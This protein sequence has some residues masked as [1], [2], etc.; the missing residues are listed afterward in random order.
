MASSDDEDRNDTGQEEDIT[1]DDDDI[2]VQTAT[3]HTKID[4]IGEE[5]TEYTIRYEI[6]YKKGQ[7]NKTD[8]KKHVS[9]LIIMEKAFDQTELRIIDNKNQRVKSFE[10]AKWM[11]NA[12]YNSHFTV[13]QDEGQRKTVIVHRIRSK[14][15][16]SGL[17]GES[18]VITYLKSSNTFLRAHFWKEDEV[19][20]RDIGFL[21]RYV[22]THHNKE[23]VLRD[24]KER[25][26]FADND[27][28]N[29]QPTPPPFQLI[30]SQ[31]RIK[32]NNKVLKTH[33]YSVQVQEKD[34]AK[35]NQYL[36]KIY[37]EEPLF[38]PYSTKKKNPDIVARAM[39]KQ[40][41]QMA[42]T[43]II[44]VVGINREVMEA[45]GNE[46]QDINGLT[47]ISETNK[48]D[49]TGRWNIIVKFK[50]FKEIRK[51]ITANLNTWIQNLPDRLQ[52]SLPDH[53]PA[54]QVNQK[55]NDTDDDSSA[56]HASYMSSCAQSY[57][58]G[59]FDE[60]DAD[61][62]TY[63]TPANESNSRSYAA[64]VQTNAVTPM[65]NE[66]QFQEKT[67]TAIIAE[68]KA[69]IATLK[70]QHGNQTPSTVTATS[71][72]DTATI[73]RL[74]KVE[75]RIHDVHAWMNEMVT[76]MRASNIDNLTEPPNP[77][78]YLPNQ[79]PNQP[80]AMQSP[81]RQP[82][83][84]K[85]N[86]ETPERQIHP[87]QLFREN[88]QVVEHEGPGH[89]HGHGHGQGQG[90]GSAPP[91]PYASYPP[92]GYNYPYPMSQPP[93]YQPPYPPQ[94]YYNPPLL[95]QEPMHTDDTVVGNSKSLPAEGAG[96]Y[97]A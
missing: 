33:A 92:I 83:K 60:N 23:F 75:N 10:D 35:M 12:Y 2:T 58:S 50:Q 20:L 26:Y 1:I 15:A 24:M 9:L 16:I 68:L 7:A 28:V 40:N 71:T 97:H 93:H 32:I 43:Y 69:E 74:D 54:P 78:N 19:L 29:T 94:P 70:L 42:E 53:F 22:P 13:N 63:F 51:K 86:R 57:G 88:N 77:S 64:V 80:N 72:P 85:H 55:Y 37:S 59:S 95:T 96:T 76:L 25:L 39:V 5:M 65:V 17:K 3:T 66:V 36:R 48:T 38:I 84:R 11:D 30:H 79:G 18:T 67:S 41:K 45:L 8:Y 56:G 90:G 82:A 49:R 73:D 46:F 89:G 44:V 34:S 6:P 4:F 91:H 52:A 14:D 27:W 47:E 81:Q 62:T 21:L 61:N 31:P 87:Q